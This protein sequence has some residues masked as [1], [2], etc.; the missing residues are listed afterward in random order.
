MTAGASVC[1]F[2]NI[3]LLMLLVLAVWA[4][5]NVCMLLVKQIL[6]YILLGLTLFPHSFK[7]LKGHLL[8]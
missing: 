1:S 3:L 4:G 2:I 7:Y 8:T 6:I 5:T